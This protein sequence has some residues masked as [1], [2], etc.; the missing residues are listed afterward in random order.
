MA[1]RTAGSPLSGEKSQSLLFLGEQFFS[2][3]KFISFF[4]RLISYSSSSFS[5]CCTHL[6]HLN[7]CKMKALHT[8]VVGCQP[9]GIWRPELE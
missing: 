6:E 7:S 1:S 9:F 3:E 2:V 4:I 5:I 8:Q